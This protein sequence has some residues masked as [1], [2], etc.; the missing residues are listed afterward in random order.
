[1]IQ[2]LKEAGVDLQADASAATNGNPH[3]V[4]A[5]DAD[6]LDL[7]S[8]PVTFDYEGDEKSWRQGLPPGEGSQLCE[9]DMSKSDSDSSVAFNLACVWMDLMETLG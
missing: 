5:P 3:E 7:V 6:N 4:A 9:I 2:L 8:M 1:M